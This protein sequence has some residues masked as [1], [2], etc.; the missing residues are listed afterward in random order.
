M[1]IEFLPEKSFPQNLESG[2]P[3]GQSFYLAFSNSVD[4]KTLKKSCVLFGKDFDRSTGPENALSLN[5]SDATN[6]F[7]LKSPGLHGFIECDFEEYFVENF[8]DE[9]ESEIQYLTEATETK[10]TIVK[11]TP[12]Q[13]LGENQK[14]TL[15]ILGETSET[16][17]ENVPGYSS[18]LSKNET[19]SKR[20]IYDATKDGVYD[21]R[22][23]TKGSFESKNGENGSKLKIKIVETGQGSK[24]KFVWWFSD[25]Q[26]PLIG[27]EI[28]KK[29]LN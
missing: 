11:V 10:N 23:R 17:N 20:T 26:E 7:F 21:E 2:F 19:L 28:Y 5:T 14:Y 24:A 13:I 22:V 27:N 16:I 1:S 12:K 8:E 6:P 18:V 25:E 4:L 9:N 15:F 3:V 29:R